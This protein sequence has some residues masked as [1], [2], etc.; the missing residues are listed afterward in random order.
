MGMVFAAGHRGEVFTPGQRAKN[1]G[2]SPA[3]VTKMLDRLEAGG[4]ITRQAHP[5]DR[6]SQAVEVTP[7]THVAA[8]EQVGRHHA[9]RFEA[10]RRLTPEE[11][12]VVIRFLGGTADDL[13]S[14]ITPPDSDAE[15]NGQP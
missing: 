7:E 8:R 10:A 1:G 2:N 4:H 12:E 15:A 3:S 11:R 5:T 6:R 14:S 13:E 9:A